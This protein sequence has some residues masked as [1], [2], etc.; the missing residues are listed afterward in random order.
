MVVGTEI[1]PHL[2]SPCLPAVLGAGWVPG[3][4]EHDP[5]RGWDVADRWHA[6][7]HALVGALPMAAL[8]GW[9]LRRW[10]PD[11]AR[12]RAA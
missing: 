10:R 8:Y 9:A 2:V 11:V 4:C 7:D 5:E 12:L 3:V 1:V 6:L